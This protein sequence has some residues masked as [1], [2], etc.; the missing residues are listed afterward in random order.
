MKHWYHFQLNGALTH[1]LLLTCMT[2]YCAATRRAL[3]SYSC[4]ASMEEASPSSVLLSSLLA[5][6][7]AAFSLASPCRK[8]STAAPAVLASPG[9]A[10][11]AR[12]AICNRP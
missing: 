5:C 2:S 12:A 7:C 10:R 4:T 6:A 11:V 9:A 8:L 3:A 1:A